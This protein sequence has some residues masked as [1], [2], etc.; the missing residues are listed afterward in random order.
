MAL[1]TH[2][3]TSG[4]SMSVHLQHAPRVAHLDD[5]MDVDGMEEDVDAETED[6]EEEDADE[7]VDQLD[8]DTEDEAAAKPAPSA[9]A[10]RARQRRNVQRVAGQT[11]IPLDRVETILDADGEFLGLSCL[12]GV[13]M[14]HWFVLGM[15]S[16]MSREALF[17]LAAAT[18][19]WFLDL[20]GNT[21]WC[22]HIGRLR[23]TVS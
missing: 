2:T 6:E 12:L 15:G 11:A 1:N 5:E 3:H 20:R 22:I 14:R 10:P 17:T 23:Q 18:V 16:Y 7:E 19:C 21:H 4:T 9:S 8:S 13:L